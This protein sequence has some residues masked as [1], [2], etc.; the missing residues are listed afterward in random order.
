MTAATAHT[1][2]RAGTVGA[3]TIA[4]MNALPP[5]LLAPLP[6][7]L[8]HSIISM[9]ELSAPP[10]S[11]LEMIPMSL[12]SLLETMMEILKGTLLTESCGSASLGG[13]SCYN[14]WTCRA[15]IFLFPLCPLSLLTHL[16]SPFSDSHHLYLS[17]ALIR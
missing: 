11:L 1:H 16:G 13:A 14:P 17:I 9:W 12:I 10:P 5:T 6:I 2:V 8:S 7:V 4:I 15:P 3:P